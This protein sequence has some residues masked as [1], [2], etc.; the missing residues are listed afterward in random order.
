MREDITAIGRRRAVV[1]ESARQ[2]HSSGFEIAKQAGRRSADSAKDMAGQFQ[3]GRG[4]CV[5]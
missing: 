5:M 4:D 1:D 2:S 3:P